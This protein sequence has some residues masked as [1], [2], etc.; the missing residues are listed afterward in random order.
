MN[1]NP[2]PLALNCLAIK[3]PAKGLRNA[4]F[5]VVKIICSTVKYTTKILATTAM[6]GLIVVLTVSDMLGL[7]KE[8]LLS[9]INTHK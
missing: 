2:G 5:N 6:M 1:W 9:C 4:F 7:H 3:R 8:Y